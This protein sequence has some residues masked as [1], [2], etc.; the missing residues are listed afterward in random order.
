MEPGCANGM[1]GSAVSLPRTVRRSSARCSSLMTSSTTDTDVT[2]GT[3]ET[4][5]VTRLVIVSRIGQPETVRYTST[6]TAPSGAIWTSL[7]MPS[8]VSGR[9]I[10]GSWTVARAAV[11]ASSVGE[12]VSVSDIVAFGLLRR[13]SPQAAGDGVDLRVRAALPLYGGEV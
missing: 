3:A 5:C 11:T 2:P 6:R 9:L 8:S 10:S 12:P 4:A 7:T 13:G 1:T